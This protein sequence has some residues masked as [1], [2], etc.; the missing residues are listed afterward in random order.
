LGIFE[1]GKW[2]RLHDQR[3]QTD[4]GQ[5]WYGVFYAKLEVE[6]DRIPYF[7]HLG[8]SAFDVQII[9]RDIL[10]LELRML[11]LNST[12]H[13]YLALFIPDLG[14]LISILVSVYGGHCLRIEH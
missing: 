2:E 11:T 9:C 12:P 10:L 7:D 1:I 14:R 13:E 4:N 8:V 3:K 5:V 6:L